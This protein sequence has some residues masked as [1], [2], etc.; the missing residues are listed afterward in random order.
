MLGKGMDFLSQIAFK[1]CVRMRDHPIPGFRTHWPNLA[2]IDSSKGRHKLTHCQRWMVGQN[3]S[4]RRFHRHFDLIRA[5]WSWRQFPV[6]RVQSKCRRG[7][8]QRNGF[9]RQHSRPDCWSRSSILQC[10]CSTVKNAAI[11][12]YQMRLNRK[13]QIEPHPDPSISPRQDWPCNN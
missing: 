3:T 12:N 4:R 6:S 9:Q 10:P 11:K 7:L 2:C 1:L 8:K 13:V 5:I